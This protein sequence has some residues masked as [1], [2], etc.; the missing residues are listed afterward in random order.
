MV[1]VVMTTTTT[2]STTMA[3]DVLGHIAVEREKED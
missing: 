2:T 1:V 3:G